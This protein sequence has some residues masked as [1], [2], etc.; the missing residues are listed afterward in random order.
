MWWRS[1]T[2]P[3]HSRVVIDTSPI[4]DSSQ[5]VSLFHHDIIIPSRH[6]IHTMVAYS[7]YRYIDFLLVVELVI[8]SLVTTFLSPSSSSSSPLLYEQ[9]TPSLSSSSSSI[10]TIINVGAV[11][12]TA[13]Q[14][15]FLEKVRAVVYLNTKGVDFAS[16]FSLKCT[17]VNDDPFYDQLCELYYPLS[18]LSAI[19]VSYPSLFSSLSIPLS[20]AIILSYLPHLHRTFISLSLF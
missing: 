20:I 7:Y 10:P 3:L 9:L 17:K 1:L 19:R 2:W 16:L 8:L 5:H 11:L 6:P 4:L 18:Q 13:A 15:D 14:F 12:S